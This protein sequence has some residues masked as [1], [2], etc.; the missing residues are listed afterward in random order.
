MYSLIGN[1]IR[2][3]ALKYNTILQLLATK[4]QGTLD[5][6]LVRVLLSQS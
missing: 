1:T 4:K 6:F 5:T 2:A 3:A